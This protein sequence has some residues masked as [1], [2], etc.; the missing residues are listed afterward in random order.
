MK[1]LQTLDEEFM[2]LA[3]NQAM[4]AAEL[5]EVPVGAVIVKGQ[6]V[7]SYGY[8]Q[9]ESS[10]NA[11]AHA[12]II[13]INSACQALKTWRLLDCAIYITMEPCPMCMGAILNA[14][15]SRL[16]F[17]CYDLKNGCC[18]SVADFK[19]FAF[20]HKKIVVFGGVMQQ[21]AAA[22]LSEFFKQKRNKKN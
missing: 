19:N 15:I 10:N 20:T 7:V 3:L 5:D 21:E 1:P 13:A 16:V 11:L 9:R 2:K 8:N 6:N 4:R 14:R 22:L 17:G 12:E 18:G